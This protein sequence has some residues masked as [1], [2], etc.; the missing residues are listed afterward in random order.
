MDI[1]QLKREFGK[2]LT[3]C[4]GLNTQRLLP[5]GTESEIRD[6]V[7]RLKDEMG[8]GGGYIL[9]PGI[10]VLADVPLENIIAAIEEAQK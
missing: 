2:D 9:E 7:R 5:L 6:E 10:T 3:L 4:G 1:Y 8:K